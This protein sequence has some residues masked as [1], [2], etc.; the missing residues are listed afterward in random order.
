MLMVCT[1]GKS[2]QLALSVSMRAVRRHLVSSLP[3]LTGILH[4][5]LSILVLASCIDF[6]S[7]SVMTVKNVLIM[8]GAATS[9]SRPTWCAKTRWSECDTEYQ[10]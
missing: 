4:I 6:P 1:A 5:L 9:W 10:G 2:I 3:K 8:T 7:I